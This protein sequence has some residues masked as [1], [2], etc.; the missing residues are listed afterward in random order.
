MSREHPTEGEVVGAAVRLYEVVTN[1]G[2]DNPTSPLGKERNYWDPELWDITERLE[3]LV[4]VEVSS[5]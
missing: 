5:V 4:G 1:Y 2:I 3:K